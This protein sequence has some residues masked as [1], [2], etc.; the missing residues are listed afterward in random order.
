MLVFFDCFWL[1]DSVLRLV[2]LCMV[3]RRTW[4]NQDDT[5]IVRLF[6]AGHHR[7]MTER[8]LKP[9]KPM[10]ENKPMSGKQ[11]NVK[12]I[13]CYQGNAP[14]SGGCYYR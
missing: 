12:E 7:F 2:V 8:L 10:S 1:K 5:C 13:H 9:N 4:I 11:A 14:M 3:C 6:V